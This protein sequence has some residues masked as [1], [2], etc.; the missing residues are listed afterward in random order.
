MIA[1]VLRTEMPFPRTV[2]CQGEAND[3]LFSLWSDNFKGGG[4]WTKNPHTWSIV[5]DLPFLNRVSVGWLI[6]DKTS[7]AGFV[8][9]HASR[10]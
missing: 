9:I 10:L 4:G 3:K 5:L 6:R 7:I 1:G 2:G 8:I